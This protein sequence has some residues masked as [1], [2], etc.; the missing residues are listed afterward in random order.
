MA[1][2]MTTVALLGYDPC[3][4]S[5][6]RASP[7]PGPARSP[8]ANA[9]S[10]PLRRLLL[11]LPPTPGFL[12]PSSEPGASS[13][14][15]PSCQACLDAPAAAQLVAA[16]LALL[17]AVAADVL[18]GP[19]SLHLL[20]AAD[21]GTHAWVASSLP[22]E[23]RAVLGGRLLSDAAICLGLVGWAAAA[24]AALGPPAP[25][26]SSSGG[27]SGSAAPAVRQRLQLRLAAAASAY[28]LA[29]GRLLH[30][31]PPL[32]AALKEAAHRE[33]PSALLHS[34]AWPSGH[35]TAATFIV[36][37]LLY[38]LLPELAVLRRAELA[39]SEPQQQRQW[40]RQPADGLA[41]AL[42]SSRG[43]LW[44]TAIATTAAGRIIADVH[45]LSDTLAGACLGC[46]VVGGTAL[47][48]HAI[49]A[50]LERAAVA[51]GTQ[52]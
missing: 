3:Q 17:G 33:R 24:A 21:W 20:H 22:A 9:V 11:L 47:L 15:A 23:V 14:A 44:P 2:A 49:D 4:R 18:G 26:P 25:I 35:T 13:T 52:R 34:W 32:V 42:L 5:G 12:A 7:A 39:G 36:G 51:A 41:S 30:A 19:A 48:C 28:A 37:A 6:R 45:W 31:D 29:G 8:H 40:Q 50:A 27:G 38:L 43:W 10:P 16:A 1:A 46:S